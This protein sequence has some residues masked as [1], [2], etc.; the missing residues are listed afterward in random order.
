MDNAFNNWS[1]SSCY[2]VKQCTCQ[3]ICGIFVRL[4][5]K[6][7]L[8]SITQ[9]K[10]SKKDRKSNIESHI[11]PTAFASILPVNQPKPEK[12]TNTE[13]FRL[14]HQHSHFRDIEIVS[15]NN[16]EISFFRLNKQ[17]SFTVPLMAAFALIDPVGT[18][19]LG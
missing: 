15:R 2:N 17:A 12:K 7:C 6:R 11:T 9:K 14:Y 8:I 19:K 18:T 13:T 1:I 16:Q 5:T 3:D 4:F 10:I